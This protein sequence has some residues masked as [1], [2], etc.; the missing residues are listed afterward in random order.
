MRIVLHGG[1]FWGRFGF[2][3]RVG[4]VCEISLCPRESLTVLDA[5]GRGP[6]YAGTHCVALG[7][8]KPI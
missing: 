7:V 5:T 8:H 4:L 2:S 3:G 1:Q 6:I